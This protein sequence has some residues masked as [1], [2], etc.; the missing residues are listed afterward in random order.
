MSAQALLQFFEVTQPG[1]PNTSQ[2]KSNNTNSNNTSATA[3]IPVSL[4]P[5]DVPHFGMTHDTI[6]ELPDEFFIGLAHDIDQDVSKLFFVVVS[7][8]TQFTEEGFSYKSMP[9]VE[10]LKETHF[11]GSPDD[12]R[13]KV[14][15][16]KLDP[17]I[18]EI[19]FYMHAKH[20]FDQMSPAMLRVITPTSVLGV[21]LSQFI[22]CKVWL[23]CLLC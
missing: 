11:P 8:L 4:H 6:H 12:H 17:N 13:F 16:S 22:L 14:Q 3:L 21:F 2:A 5:T 23:F 10:S 7:D 15:L 19:W 18:E 1:V 20:S 9:G